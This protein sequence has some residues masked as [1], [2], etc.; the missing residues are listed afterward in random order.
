MKPMFTWHYSLFIVLFYFPNVSYGERSFKCFLKIYRLFKFCEQSLCWNYSVLSD[1]Y[2]FTLII[3]SVTVKEIF[4]VASQ[5]KLNLLF[6]CTILTTLGAKKLSE[7][8]IALF[9]GDITFI[10][11]I[12]KW[13]VANMLR[14]SIYM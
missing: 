12:L 6:Q 3:S 5:K 9:Y 11:N 2:N 8:W 14:R 7:S 13:D 1:S 4:A 10:F